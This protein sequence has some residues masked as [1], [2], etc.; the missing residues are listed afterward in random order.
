MMERTL[1]DADHQLFADMVRRFISTEITPFHSQWEKD[2]VVPREIW[3]KAGANGLLCTSISPEYGGPGGD[4][5][6]GAI[7]TE[8]M[9]RVVAG[10]P[11]FAL[12]S[13]IIAPYMATYA[14][15]ALKQQWLPAMVR[16]EVISAIAMTEPDA[17]SDLQSIRTRAIDDGDNYVINGQKTYISNGQL[18]D[19]VILACKTNDNPGA[20]GTSLI[21]VETDRSGFKRGRNLEKIGMLSLIHI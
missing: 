16:G 1:Y 15:E 13:D 9:S 8:E 14:S 6:H 11:N 17:G 7:V 12:H 21:L 19:I 20:K 5:L 2:G 3:A 18:C 10:G 4:F